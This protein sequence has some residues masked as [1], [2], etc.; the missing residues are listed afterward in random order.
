MHEL[1]AVLV[2]LLC[3]HWGAIAL[4]VKLQSLPC[5]ELAGGSWVNNKAITS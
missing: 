1:C 2:S 3:P 5:D 4:A